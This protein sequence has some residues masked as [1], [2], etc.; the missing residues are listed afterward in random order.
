MFGR[1]IH[2]LF[3]VLRSRHAV[4]MICTQVDWKAN[5]TRAEYGGRRCRT[6]FDT[7]QPR[8][9][10][11]STWTE[12]TG[13]LGKLQKRFGVLEGVVQRKVGTDGNGFLV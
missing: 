9:E 7:S 8:I 10:M 6:L 5:T 13:W 11:I 3:R 1:A 2:N 12:T 4:K